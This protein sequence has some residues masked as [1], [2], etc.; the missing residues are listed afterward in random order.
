MKLLAGIGLK[1]CILENEF[2]E[3]GLGPDMATH[4]SATPPHL[5]PIFEASAVPSSA[6]P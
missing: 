5:L 1:L 4:H 3:E 6:S 2:W